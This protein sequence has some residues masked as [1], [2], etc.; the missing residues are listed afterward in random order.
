MGRSATLE[1]H[2]HRFAGAA[3]TLSLLRGAAGLCAALLASPAR[4]GDETCGGPFDA[5]PTSRNFRVA[6]V[7]H[8]PSGFANALAVS[9]DGQRLYA[10]TL[11]GVWRSDD[12][13]LSWY[14]M[15]R[16]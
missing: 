3:M 16:P 12:G 4:G 14:Q 13:G 1:S 15:T 2:D 10:G 7:G 5:S 11:S 6:D 9:A 8:S